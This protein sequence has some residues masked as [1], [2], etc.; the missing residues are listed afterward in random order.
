MS[1]TVSTRISAVV[2]GVS[3][4]M[5]AA[6]GGSGSTAGTVPADADVTVRAKEGL[7][8]DA[9]SYTATSHDGTVILYGVNDSG[10]AH[11]LHIVDKDDKDVTTGI[12]LAGSGSSGTMTL[13]VAPGEYRIVCKIPGHSGTMNATLT[14]N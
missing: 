9:K 10:L 13:T 8:W 4:A 14:V 11:N 5:L 12:D 7:V 6:C 3:L 1:S 2:L